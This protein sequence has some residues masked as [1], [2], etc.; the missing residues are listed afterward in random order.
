VIARQTG[1]APP[2]AAVIHV[3]DCVAFSESADVCGNHFQSRV[4]SATKTHKL[5]EMRFTIMMEKYMDALDTGVMSSDALKEYG[6]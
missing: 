4:Q 1:G 5:I 6:V 2:G 3:C